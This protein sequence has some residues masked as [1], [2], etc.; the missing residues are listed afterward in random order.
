MHL[1]TRSVRSLLIVFLVGLAG[2][3]CTYVIGNVGDNFNHRLS[4]IDSIYFTIT[5]LSTSIFG[6][7]LP[8]TPIAKI[9]VVLLSILG[10]GAFVNAVV[11]ISG[12]LVAKNIVS[13]SE[14]LEKVEEELD[15]PRFLLIG[16]G[17]VNYLLARIL[18]DRKEKYVLL[19]SSKAKADRLRKEG[20]KAYRIAEISEEE[21][22]KFHPDKANSIIVDI[23]NV[24]D[25]LYSLLILSEIAKTT[26]LVTIVYNKE[27]EKR[28]QTLKKIKEIQIINPDKIVAEQLVEILS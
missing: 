5:T 24:S 13:L 17:P 3:I 22:M 20:I 15:K 18:K 12:D 28:I 19:V 7:I 10:I 4:I 14:K 6:D 16:N 23:R 1:S 27:A 26:K 21:L 11:N 9:Y 8:V 25:M 2:I